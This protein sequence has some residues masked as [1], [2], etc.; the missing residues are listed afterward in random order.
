M[1]PPPPLR[2]SI[3]S[4]VAAAWPAFQDLRA[5][6]GA[7]AHKERLRNAVS[8]LVNELRVALAAAHLC[9]RRSLIG[10]GDGPLSEEDHAASQ[11]CVS[12]AE[13]LCDLARMIVSDGELPL[14][15]FWHLSETQARLVCDQLRLVVGPAPG[16]A[17]QLVPAP[18]SGPV[19]QRQAFAQAPHV[20]LAAVASGLDLRSALSLFG[21][22]S[23]GS[24]SFDDH[25]YYPV[26]KGLGP[27]SARVSLLGAAERLRFGGADGEPGWLVYVHAG[28]VAAVVSS[29]AVRVRWLDDLRRAAGG[30]ESL[31][32]FIALPRDEHGRPIIP[33]SR[34]TALVE[35]RQAWEVELGQIDEVTRTIVGGRL[36]MPKV[37]FPSQQIYLR[38]HP[39]W[40][41]DAAA[42]QALGPVIAKWLA[43]GV[44]E[45][46]GWNDRAP[47]LLQPCGAV[48]K[49]TAPFYRLIT[50][51]R[52]A[53]DMYA[54]WGVTYTTAAQLS[55]VLN[56]CDFTFSIDIS[57]AYHL[58]LWAGC[59]GE[60]RPTRRPVVSTAHDSEPRVTWIDALING[61]DPST[62]LGGCD[63]DLSGIVIEGHIFR[64]ASCQ[65][66]QKTAGSPLG[67]LVRS[68]ARYFARLPTPVHVA[69]W[70]DDLIFIMSTPEHD[71]CDGLRADAPSA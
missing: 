14:R 18:S 23:D 64:F 25:A 21:N 28:E 41:N 49:G 43:T 55:S 58:A 29:R 61:C 27:L 39:S 36:V 8:I 17:E 71:V 63:K 68:V 65:F 45:Y 44:L 12:R 50:D 37:A 26:G 60:L 67:S 38:N 22:L 16:R 70:V 66:G 3:L 56:R 10:G 32:D 1:R 51:A 53:N 42:K 9:S 46:V 47:L 7:Y 33:T 24:Y 31:P 19:P 40:E 2:A 5:A 13:L 6:A 48:P 30:L 62:C 54:D 57:D 4:H 15:D 35:A 20:F 34:V 52:R 11:A 69:A 59:G